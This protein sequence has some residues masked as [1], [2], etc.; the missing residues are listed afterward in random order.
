MRVMGID[1]GIASTGYGIVSQVQGR[2][3]FEQAGCIRTC[4]DQPIACRLQ[5]IYN[6]LQGLIALHQPQVVALEEVFV[7]NNCKLSLDLGQAIGVAR[8]AA[9]QAG[10]EV[11]S[12]SAL[13]VKQAVVGYGRAQKQQVQ[14]MVKTLLALPQPPAND[15]AAD[16]LAVAICH[17]HTKIYG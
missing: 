10:L 16:A 8:L 3:K 11:F 14:V 6:Q 4:A 7:A 2:L 5:L 17:L 13:Q 9:V 12:Y 15:H 1:P